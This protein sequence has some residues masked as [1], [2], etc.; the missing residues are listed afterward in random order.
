[1]S[2]RA[3]ELLQGGQDGEEMDKEAT[4]KTTTSANIGKIQQTM[5]PAAYVAKVKQVELNART[6]NEFFDEF[7]LT[8]RFG[9]VANHVGRL[10]YEKDRDGKSIYIFK[11]SFQTTII[12]FIM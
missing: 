10:G 4:K 3:R 7:D 12:K 5:T 2:K 11:F 8:Y 1:M 6:Q 9:V